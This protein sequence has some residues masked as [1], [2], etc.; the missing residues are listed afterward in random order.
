MPRHWVASAVW[1]HPEPI[2]LAFCQPGAYLL[3]GINSCFAAMHNQS[4]KFLGQFITISLSAVCLV[5]II[6]PERLWFWELLHALLCFPSSHTLMER[7]IPAFPPP[8]PPVH[9]NQ[10]HWNNWSSTQCLVVWHW[11]WEMN[12]QAGKHAAQLLHFGKFIHNRFPL[13]ESPWVG[14][15]AHF[16]FIISHNSAVLFIN[17]TGGIFPQNFP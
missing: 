15:S 12:W 9:G 10:A 13:I 17:T 2:T 3:P 1:L 8:F 6:I 5:F 16:L 4:F 7:E 11:G 14:L